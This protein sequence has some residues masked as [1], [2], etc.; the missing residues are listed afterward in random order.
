MS[1]YL[2]MILKNTGYTLGELIRGA[3]MSGKVVDHSMDGGCGCRDVSGNDVGGNGTHYYCSCSHPIR[4]AYEVT[5]VSTGEKFDFGSTCIENWKIRCPDC[6]SVKEFDECRTNTI[7]Q[8]YRCLKCDAVFF[9][10][11]REYKRQQRK[12]EKEREEAEMRKFLE[13]QVEEEEKKRQLKYMEILRQNKERDDLVARVE[14]EYDDHIEMVTK[15][16]QLKQRALEL[17]KQTLMWSLLRKCQVCN[18][19]SI[20]KDAPAHFTKCLLCF[21]TV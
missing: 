10:K 12:E 1:Y 7:D 21:K 4:W 15:F 13:K 11:R 3:V 9:E 2:D 6:D 17:E 16:K 19:L 5:Y 20:D 8:Y 14:K 18:K